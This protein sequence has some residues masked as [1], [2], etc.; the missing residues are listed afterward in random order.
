MDAPAFA[1]AKMAQFITQTGSI[2]Y[3]EGRIETWQAEGVTEIAGESGEGTMVIQGPFFP[4]E[5]LDSVLRDSGRR[6]E[7]LDAVRFWFQA[8]RSRQSRKE[9]GG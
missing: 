8:L 9:S 3:P 5:C 1:Q 7:S 6:E 4:G 2:V